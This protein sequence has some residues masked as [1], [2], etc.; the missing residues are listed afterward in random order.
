MV[1]K[2]ETS[3]LFTNWDQVGFTPIEIATDG[4]HLF[5]E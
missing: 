5:L 4:S 2:K 3:Q 1:K